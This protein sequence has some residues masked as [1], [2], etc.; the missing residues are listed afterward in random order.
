MEALC[1]QPYRG[2]LSSGGRVLDLAAWVQ[3]LL[4]AADGQTFEPALTALIN[5]IMAFNS[6]NYLSST[7][8]LFP[9]HNTTDFIPL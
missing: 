1:S 2:W 4:T 9:G 3:F 8:I 6:N 5:V 7:E